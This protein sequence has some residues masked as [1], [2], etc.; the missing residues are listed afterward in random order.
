MGDLFSKPRVTKLAP[1]KPVAPPPIDT[2]GQAGEQVRKQR[3][4]GRETTFITGD[5]V[6]EKK[7][8]TTLG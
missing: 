5:L 8:K 6:P 3:P 1:P 2:A 7:K 4:S